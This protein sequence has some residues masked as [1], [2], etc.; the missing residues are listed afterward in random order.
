[1]KKIL[2]L[3]VLTALVYTGC[4]K[5][6]NL[7]SVIHT[8]S[9]PIISVS[10]SDYY[11][12]MVGGVIPTITA[13]SFD[14]FYQASYQVVV[15][16]SSINVNVPGLYTV[17]LSAKNLYGMEGTKDVYVAVTNISDS[18][19]LSGWYQYLSIANRSAYVTKLARG[20]FMTSN[21]GGADTTDITTGPVV[22]ALFAV[23]GN[24]S[25]DLGTQSTTDG[26]LTASSEALNMVPADTTL[27]YALN[28]KGFSTAVRSFKKQ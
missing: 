27:N 23:T 24:A 12:M 20:I 6:E 1:M 18:L 2:I 11:S 9:T 21:V 19:D 28:L 4:K 7:V 15:D 22:S 5:P 16:N 14:T 10:G 26:T 3:S 13:T 25:L 17:V 8:Y